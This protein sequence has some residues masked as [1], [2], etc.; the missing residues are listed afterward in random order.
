MNDAAPVRVLRSRPVSRAAAVRELDRR[1]IE[2]V[3]VPGPVLME[4]AAHGVAD[5]ILARWPTP[6]RVAI[7][8]GPGNNGGDG[9]AIAR[10]LA[11]RGIAVRCVPLFEP[12]SADAKVHAHVAAKLGLVGPWDGADLVVDALFG[13]GQRAPLTLPELPPID[14]LPLVAVD[15]PTGIDADTGAR[16]GAFP[17]V[18]AV[19][20]IG[21]AKPFLFV[22]PIPWDLVDIG[23]ELC[24]ETAGA[25]P[26]EAVLV[27]DAA[28]PAF[29][30]SSNKW[31]R[32]HV[33]VYA[34]SEELAGAGVLACL[35]ALRGGA[36]LVT[37]LVP[38]AAWGRL[39]ALPPEVM[40]RER[41]QYDRYDA[42]VLG[43]GLGR[44]ADAEVRRLW[45]EHPRPCVFDAD[46]L[47]ALDGTASPHPRLITPHAGEASH[48]L[49]TPWRDLEGDR[50]ATA[51]RLRAIAPAIYKGAC[52]LVTGAP[53]RVLWGAN[54][55]MGTGGTG[56]VLA[57]LAGAILARHRPNARD[58]VETCALAAA[59]L[60]LRAG[61]LAGPVGI[62]ARDVADAIPRAR[63]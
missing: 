21:R 16:V 44:S 20:T 29:P 41:G 55:A 40:V 23:L 36:G 2:D 4:H 54:P 58:D 63:G 1:L 45:A 60:H 48:L 42:L 8:C 6:G 61:A 30:A 18:D 39:G 26:P 10:H 38:K 19:V 49:G 17:R 31:D 15:V 57:G 33:G 9:Y 5:A 35:G 50:L 51:A 43:P 13:T 24:A 53:L 14:G 47:K 62:G 52:P 56:D 46:A 3:G 34:G 28:L 22:D 37:L 12:K 7:L 25:E 11:A 59:W 32:G 27:D